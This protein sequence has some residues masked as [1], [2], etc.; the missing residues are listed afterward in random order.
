MTGAQRDENDRPNLLVEGL[1]SFGGVAALVIGSVYIA[2][3]LIKTVDLNHAGISARDALPLFPLELILRTGL[4]LVAPVLGLVALVGTVMTAAALYERR[5]SQV[6][7]SFKQ[8][9]LDRVSDRSWLERYEIA[10]EETNWDVVKERVSVALKEVKAGGDAAQVKAL[11]RQRLAFTGFD[12]LLGLGGGVAG[13][14]ALVTL[15]VP[16]LIAFFAGTLLIIW[17]SHYVREQPVVKAMGIYYVLL[18]VLLIVYLLAY[19]RP[20]SIARISTDNEDDVVSGRLIVMSD[21]NWYLGTEGVIRPI[22]Q[23]HAEC[24]VIEPQATKQN[25]ILTQIFGRDTPEPQTLN[26]D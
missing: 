16:L 17:L 19:P 7:E 10:Q 8:A 3:I 24:V 1:R 4:T 23:D 26:C 11:R 6:A 13:L 2:G 21:S 14:L 22:S 15:P 25:T 9:E 20:L 12:A 5:L 18:A